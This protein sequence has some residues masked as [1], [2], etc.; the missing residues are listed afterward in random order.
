MVPGGAPLSVFLTLL[1]IAVLDS[2]EETRWLAE[3]MV[4]P[5]G[6]CP[7]GGRRPIWSDR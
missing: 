5:A 6:G 2:D 7:A 4:S 3:A 1:V